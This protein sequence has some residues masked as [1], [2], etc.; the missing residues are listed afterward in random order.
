MAGEALVVLEANSVH[1]AVAEAEARLRGLRAE[2]GELRGQAAAVEARRTAAE[3]KG[4]EERRATAARLAAAA[5]EAVEAEVNA[6]RAEG[7]GGARALGAGRV[8]SR[9]EAEALGAADWRGPAA[10]DAAL[11]TV[12]AL[13]QAG[14]IR[15]GDRVLLQGGSGEGKSTLGLLLLGLWS[16]EAGSLLLRGLDRETWGWRRPCAGSWASGSSSSGCRRASTRWW[17]RWGG[18]SRAGAEPGLRRA[19]APPGGAI[20]VLDESLGALDPVSVTQAME[21]VERRA[22]TL[23]LVGHS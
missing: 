3:R 23:V 9:F 12:R 7:A 5:V 16:P 19:G 11:R 14:A 10:L 8:V 22:G 18:S 17:G 4:V 13:V 2:A 6:V 20:V 21:C 1:L 15:R